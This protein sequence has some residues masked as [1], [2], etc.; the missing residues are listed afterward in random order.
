MT[1]AEEP[2]PFHRPS[3][4]K[5]ERDAVIEVLD[6]GWLTT[7]DRTATFEKAFAAYVGVPFAIAVNSATAALHLAMDGIGIRSEH[8][9]IVPTY[10]FAASAEV[11]LYL[12]A[13][14]VLVD[15]DPTTGNIDPTAVAAALGPQTGAVEV[16]HIAGLPADIA[17]VQAVAGDLPIVEDAAHAFPSPI[18]SLDGRFAGTVGRAGAFSFYATKTITTGE[19]GMLVTADAD[20]ADRAR[21]M[22]LHGIG[23]D[24]WKRYTAEGSWY[25]EIEAAGFKDNLT[26][27]AASIG[28]VQLDRAAELRANRA[29]IASRYLAGFADA[30]RDGRLILPDAGADDEHAWHLFMLRLGP[31]ARPRDVTDMEL[32]GVAGLPDSLRLIAS[33]RARVIDSARRA[34]VGTSVHFIPLHLHPLYAR[35]GY[36]PGQFPGAEVMYASEVSLPIWP[37][38]RPSQIDRVIDIVLAATTGH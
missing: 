28:L 34:G 33:R 32:P 27:L 38:M 18:A 15:V 29:A 6:S 37:G 8:D 30:A 10:T 5:A 31:E 11:V 21:T 12:G 4:G 23:R 7:G 26:D 36:R 3:L 25:Y 13:K 1:S 24:A 9:V 17:G 14:P 35:M 2:I 22:R 19:G 16:V 20:L